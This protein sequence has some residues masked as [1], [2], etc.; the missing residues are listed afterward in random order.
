MAGI[1]LP[2]GDEAPEAP[3]IVQEL[4]FSAAEIEALLD[5]ALAREGWVHTKVKPLPDRLCYRV[6]SPTGAEA[7]LCF[8]AL[9]DRTFA[10][11]RIRVP[12]TR[13]RGTFRRASAEFVAG[14]QQRLQRLFLKGGG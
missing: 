5:R 6:Q 3:G 7:L 9:S 10:S 4:G 12:C 13:F 2:Q 11:G 14:W 1:S 8:D